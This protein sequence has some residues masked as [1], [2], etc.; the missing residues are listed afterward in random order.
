M[1]LARLYVNICPWSAC[2]CHSQSP[3]PFCFLLMP[4]SSVH[5]IIVIFPLSVTKPSVSPIYLNISILLSTFYALNSCDQTGNYISEQTQAFQHCKVQAVPSGEPKAPCLKPSP[6]P[7]TLPPTHVA[8]DLGFSFIGTTLS[9]KGSRKHCLH[10]R[11]V[12]VWYVIVTGYA[13]EISLVA[14]IYLNVSQ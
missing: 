11:K 10:P 12:H 14:T 7:R 2:I 9:F 8:R 3:S 6:S 13:S 1:P 5:L 4:M